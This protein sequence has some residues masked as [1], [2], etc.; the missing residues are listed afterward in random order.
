MALFFNIHPLTSTVL[1][2][3]NKAPWKNLDTLGQQNNSFSSTRGY[4]KGNRHLCNMV[5]DNFLTYNV[6][7][8]VFL[9][10]DELTVFK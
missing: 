4:L 3:E 10:P 9:S 8:A 7:T 2:F 1:M 5:S 6:T